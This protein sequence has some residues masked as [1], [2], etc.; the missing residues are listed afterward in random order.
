M[1]RL[2]PGTS[3]DEGSVSIELATIVVL[4]LI[5]VIYLVIAIGQVQAATFATD[6]AAREAVRA[7]VTAESDD[8][9]HRR[10]ERAVQLAFTDQGFD[11][12]AAGS[13]LSVE[14]SH[15]P[16][17]H[18]GATV[19]VGVSTVVPLPGFGS[20]LRSEGVGVRVEGKHTMIVDRY[21]SIEN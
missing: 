10:A 7:I 12:G 11:G 16:C 3:G 14:C 18:P 17:L 8:E 6:T 9:G 2:Q 21:F 19:S 5:P 1:D 4:L 20:E 13:A 15:D